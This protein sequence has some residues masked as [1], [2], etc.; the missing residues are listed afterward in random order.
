MSI[1]TIPT[2]ALLVD[3]NDANVAPNCSIVPECYFRYN[4]AN[5]FVYGYKLVM[6]LSTSPAYN[7]QIKWHGRHSKKVLLLIFTSRDLFLPCA[8]H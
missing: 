5:F 2:P 3:R 4:G 6:W 8:C 7:V 1:K